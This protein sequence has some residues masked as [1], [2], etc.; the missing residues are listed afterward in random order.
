MNAEIA[1]VQVGRVVDEISRVHAADEGGE[2]EG[3]EYGVPEEMTQRRV[4]LRGGLN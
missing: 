1:E 2:G 4:D 3:T